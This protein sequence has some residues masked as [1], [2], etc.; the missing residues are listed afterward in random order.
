M[1]AEAVSL[2][3]AASIYPPA[4]AAVIA[5]GRG[6]E[7]RLRVVL[8]VIAAYL[9]VMATGSLMLFLFQEAGAS[10]AQVVT[11][12]AWLYVAGGVVLFG[13]G[14]HLRRPRPTDPAAQHRDRTSRYLQSRRLV[15]ALAVVLY[16]VPSPIF[17]GAVKAVAD[18][19]AST[20]QELLYLVATLVIM[21]WLIELPMLILIAVPRRGQALLEAVNGWFGSHGRSLLALTCLAIGAYLLAIGLI[22]ASP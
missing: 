17:A 11:P 6:Q 20:S 22:E 2:A 16:V 12:A 15:A 7:V 4:L 8:F 1:P 3:L 19:G 9:T 14:L 10:R 18:S 13:V 5:L 21:L